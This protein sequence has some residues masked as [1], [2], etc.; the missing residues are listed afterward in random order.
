MNGGRNRS[1]PDLWL[2]LIQLDSS[3]FGSSDRFFRLG[4]NGEESGKNFEDDLG[5]D[6]SVKQE[7]TKDKIDKL[8]DRASPH[9]TIDGRSMVWRMGRG[10]SW[11]LGS[12]LTRG[13]LFLEGRI[14]GGIDRLGCLVV[15]VNGGNLGL[16]PSGV[17]GR[18]RR[19]GEQIVVGRGWNPIVLGKDGEMNIPIGLEEI[20]DW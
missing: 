17:H 9:G 2:I 3:H 18:G 19:R 11:E 13:Q 20:V 8:P 1:G 14:Q 16:S 5:K 4:V 12:A 15:N 6:A 10:G 7:D